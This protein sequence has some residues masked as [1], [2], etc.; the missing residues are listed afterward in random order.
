MVDEA[1]ESAVTQQLL[2]LVGPIA[3]IIVKRAGRQTRKRAEF[4]QVVAEHIDSSA[5]RALFLANTAGLLAR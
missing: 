2:V 3:R 4:L 5:D 1:W